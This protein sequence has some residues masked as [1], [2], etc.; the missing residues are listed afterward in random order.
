MKTVNQILEGKREIGNISPERGM[1]IDLENGSELCFISSVWYSNT[2]FGAIFPKGE[3]PS[4][5]DDIDWRRLDR[6]VVISARKG[7]YGNEMFDCIIEE[8]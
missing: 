7:S 3:S 2:T 5:N 6:D 1:T 8:L 4:K